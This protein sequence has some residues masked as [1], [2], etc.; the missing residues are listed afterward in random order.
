M[1]VERGWWRSDFVSAIHAHRAG[2]GSLWWFL[3]MIYTRGDA[4]V[5]MLAD[6]AIFLEGSDRAPRPTS[7]FGSSTGTEALGGSRVP[8]RT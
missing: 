3:Q 4:L 6:V 8:K 5:S 2:L 1:E 7:R